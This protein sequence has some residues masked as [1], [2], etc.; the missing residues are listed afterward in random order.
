MVYTEG[1]AANTMT[2]NIVQLPAKSETESIT[3]FLLIKVETL[4]LNEKSSQC[5]PR[6]SHREEH[7][8]LSKS[9]ILCSKGSITESAT[10]DKCDEGSSHNHDERL[11]GSKLTP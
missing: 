4:L 1:G 5:S 9:K 11:V 7:F 10:E 2:R 8:I 3:K 6:C